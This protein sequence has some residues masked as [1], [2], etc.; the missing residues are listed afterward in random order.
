MTRKLR[1]KHRLIVTSLAFL[2]PISVGTALA[3]RQ[4]FAI[5]RTLSPPLAAGVAEHGPIVWSRGDLWS[6]KKIFTSLR[7]DAM[8]HVS[9]DLMYRDLPFADLL[10]YWVPGQAEKLEGLPATARFLGTIFRGVP[11]QIPADLRG[12]VG[13]LVIYGLADHEIV[14]H[15]STFK[16]QK[17]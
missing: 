13:R 15:T 10:L 5:T 12:E 6:G 14:T 7:R 2:L 11:L 9:I 16:I 3:V 1:N 17:V 8:N 4:P